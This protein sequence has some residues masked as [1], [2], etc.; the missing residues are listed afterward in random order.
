[1][2]PRILY[3]KNNW[4]NDNETTVTMIKLRYRYIWYIIDL[5]WPCRRHELCIQGQIYGCENQITWAVI[6]KEF[7][8]IQKNSRNSTSKNGPL[9]TILESLSW[10]SLI[11][12]GLNCHGIYF[13]LCFYYGLNTDYTQA[14]I[15][16][17]DNHSV[18]KSK[19]HQI[20]VQ[21]TLGWKG[22]QLWLAIS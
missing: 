14:D 12:R 15:I 3:R 8:K 19:C 1:M 16:C 2:R 9:I 20:N 10:L 11:H 6:M 21:M 18:E 4:Q 7:S 22:A 17:Y 5:K 13:Y